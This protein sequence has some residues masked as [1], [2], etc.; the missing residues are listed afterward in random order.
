MRAGNLLS[1][2]SPFLNSILK[3]SLLNLGRARREEVEKTPP[4]E[5]IEECRAGRKRAIRGNITGQ[6][7]FVFT[8]GGRS[9]C[10]GETKGEKKKHRKKRKGGTGREGGGSG[11]AKCYGDSAYLETSKWAR[12]KRRRRKRGR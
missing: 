9:Q 6:L 3:S 7:F 8:C 12:K 10:G 11:A 5:V 1:A 2:M 4:R